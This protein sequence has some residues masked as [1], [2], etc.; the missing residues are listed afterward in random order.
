MAGQ[1]YR[2][3]MR[4]HTSFLADVEKRALVWMARRMPAGINSDHLTLLALVAMFMTGLSY[5]LASR[6]PAGLVAACFWLAVNWFGDSL[7]GTLA[8]VRGQQR[9]RYGFYVDH[10]IDAFGTSFLVGGLALSGHMS[11]AVA[12]ALLAAYFLLSIEVY[13]AAHALGRFHL[14]YFKFGPTE[15]RLLLCAASL[16]LLA[17]PRAELFGRV[18][19]PFDVGGVVAAILMVLTAAMAA[20]R[21]TRALYLEEPMPPPTRP[22]TT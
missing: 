3:A 15:L 19:R 22:L 17:E 8:R 12:M 4:I 10:V 21:H 9:P 13:L 7:D 1:P 20:V 11:P 5:W 2:N 16:A 18:Y 6:Y 14:S